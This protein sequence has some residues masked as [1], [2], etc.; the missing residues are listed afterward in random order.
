M[1]LTLVRKP[2]VR[3]P[4][5]AGGSREPPRRK[6]RAWPVPGTAPITHL[7]WNP[8]GSNWTGA[9]AGVPAFQACKP[10]DSGA[11]FGCSKPGGLADPMPVV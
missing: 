1:A 7:D 3:S 2:P 5:A 4:H 9:A 8:I 11:L 6:P 10:F